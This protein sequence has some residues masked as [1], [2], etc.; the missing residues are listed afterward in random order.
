[1]TARH[2]NGQTLLTSGLDYDEARRIVEKLGYL[3][4]AIDQAGAYLSKLAKPLHAFLPLFEANFK[5]TLNKKPPSS[6]WQ[7][8]EKTVVTTWEISFEAV[9]KEDPQ[10]AELLLLCSFLSNK[11]INSEF[12]FSGLPEMFKESKY[13]FAKLITS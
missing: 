11:D 1:M 5:I 2:K 12:L 3:P 10:A 6:V 8:G 7:Y 9:Q 13:K 4:L